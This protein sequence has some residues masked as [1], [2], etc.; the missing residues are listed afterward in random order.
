M[1]VL[2]LERV[3]SERGRCSTGRSHIENGL[4]L[5]LPSRA[6]G[7]LVI[8][9]VNELVELAIKTRYES[10]RIHDVNGEL[11]KIAHAV[12]DADPRAEDERLALGGDGIGELERSHRVRRWIFDAHP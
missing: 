5:G 10:F 2:R 1:Q 7:R 6:M 8:E 9:I 3:Q 12:Y 11:T 4:L